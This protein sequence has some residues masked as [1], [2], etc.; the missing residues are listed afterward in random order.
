M[1]SD[2]EHARLPARTGARCMR[3]LGGAAELG[4]KGGRGRAVYRLG[5]LREFAAPKTAADLRDLLAELNYRNSLRGTTTTTP[6]P[7]LIRSGSKCPR[8]EK[9]PS[10]RATQRRKR[11]KEERPLRCLRAAG[12]YR[13]GAARVLPQG[14]QSIVRRRCWRTVVSP[15]PRG[16][17]KGKK[18]MLVLAS[19]GVFTEGPRKSWDFVEPYLRKILSF[20]G[21]VSVQ[22]VRAEQR[23]GFTTVEQNY[24]VEA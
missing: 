19:G 4:S 12:S 18:A 11:A 17:E 2:A 15:P 20:I 1:G 6:R 7:R 16:E 3:T 9:S 5:D 21:I 24:R 14:A 8:L 23:S 22:T 13:T 10:E